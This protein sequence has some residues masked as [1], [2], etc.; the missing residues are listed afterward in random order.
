MHPFPL[1]EIN[2][3]WAAVKVSYNMNCDAELS[4]R[5]QVQIIIISV[6]DSYCNFLLLYIYIICNCDICY[7]VS[8]SVGC[9]GEQVADMST[10]LSTSVSYPHFI[11]HTLISLPSPPAFHFA[12]CYQTTETPNGPTLLLYSSTTEVT[13]RPQ[14]FSILTWL[15]LQTVSRC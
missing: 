6:P 12:S 15:P 11:A 13:S 9:E 7:L 2:G 4:V 3:W 14:Q 8:I 1:I 10:A 5:L